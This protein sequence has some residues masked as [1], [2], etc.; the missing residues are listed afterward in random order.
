MWHIGR[1]REYSEAL[2]TFRSRLLVLMHISGGQLARGTELVI[3]Q[4]KNGFYNNIRG[5]FIN[6]GIIMFVIAYNKI[7]NIIAQVKMIH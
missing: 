3:V 2:K 1:V 5:L 4:Y 6:N 7:I